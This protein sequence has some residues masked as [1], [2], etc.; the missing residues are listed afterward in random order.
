MEIFDRPWS[1]KMVL[2]K[3]GRCGEF[4]DP[5][6]WSAL[7]RARLADVSQIWALWRIS[8]PLPSS[9]RARRVSAR[10]GSNKGAVRKFGSKGRRQLHQIATFSQHLSQIKALYGI[11]QGALVFCANFRRR[12]SNKGAVRSSGPVVCRNPRPGLTS[13]R[14]S[15]LFRKS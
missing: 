11:L 3:Y 12:Q 13:R 7:L 10:R 2:V 8:G 1:S 9:R 6:L 5:F 14:G 4:P 15:R